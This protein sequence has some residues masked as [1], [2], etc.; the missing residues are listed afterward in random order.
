MKLNIHISY[1]P[2]IPLYHKC[3]RASLAHVY[4]RHVQEFCGIAVCNNKKNWKQLERPAIKYGMTIY[5]AFHTMERY[6]EVKMK[7]P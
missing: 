4:R 6:E 3:I 7:G 1:D 2:Q 5:L